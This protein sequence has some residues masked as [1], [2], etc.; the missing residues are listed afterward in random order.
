MSEAESETVL[1]TARPAIRCRDPA[2]GTR[3][4]AP[5]A[6]VHLLKLSERREPL[7][8]Q[9]ATWVGIGIIEGA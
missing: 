8:V 1:L 6:L 7:V 9:I 2:T 3:H 5:A 4:R